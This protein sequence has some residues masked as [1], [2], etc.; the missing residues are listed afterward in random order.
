[1]KLYQQ[2]I[3]K[4]AVLVPKPVVMMA[5]AEHYTRKDPAQAARLYGEIKTQ[6]PDTP[7]AM[8]ADQ[9]LS[10]LPGKT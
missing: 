2:L 1:V 7:I 5:L 8:Q 6:F 9:A 4:P 10:L 3:D